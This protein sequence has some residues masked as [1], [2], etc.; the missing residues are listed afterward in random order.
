MQALRNYV[1][2]RKAFLRHSTASPSS[3]PTESVFNV[4]AELLRTKR[5]RVSDDI[6][7]QHLLKA[8]NVYHYIM[9]AIVSLAAFP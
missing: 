2:V 8:N 1:L 7:K 6:Y 4:A 5:K 9:E 3:T